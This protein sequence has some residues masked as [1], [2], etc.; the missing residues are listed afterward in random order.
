MVT[1]S[2]GG[3]EEVSCSGG[4]EGGEGVLGTRGTEVSYGGV[5]EVAFT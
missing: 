1:C 2:E 4:V 3:V 5:E